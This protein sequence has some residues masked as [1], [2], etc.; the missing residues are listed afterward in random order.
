VAGELVE[1]NLS[2]GEVLQIT[3]VDS[4]AGSPIVTTKP[5]GVFGGS[6][7][8]DIPMDIGYADMTQLQIAPLTQWGTSYALV[9][10]QPRITSVSGVGRENVPWSFVGAV[11]G[12][13]LTYDPARPEGAPETLNAGEV[14][15]FLTTD[16]VTVKSQDSKHPFHVSVV[17][18]GT[19]FGGGAEGGGWTLGDPDYMG[20]VPSDQFL[21]HYIFFADYTFP[22]TSLT[23]VRRRTAD[24]FK[25]VT[26]AC[27]GGE[28]TGWQ[29]V[30]ASGEYE[31]TWVSLTTGGVPQKVGTGTCSYGRHEAT[32]EGPFSVAVWGV[33][34]HASYGYP[35]GRGSRPINDAPPPIVQ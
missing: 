17:M 21:D 3:Q 15:T 34:F 11:D 18:T 7:I 29:P 25:P 19:D 23:L 35:G 12:T 24:G 32:S 2:K 10:Y 9:P 13:V 5:V 27:A 16:L 8:T 4:A 31:F 14:V 6:P 22:D 28:I 1:W 20:I 26:L 33:A 30:G